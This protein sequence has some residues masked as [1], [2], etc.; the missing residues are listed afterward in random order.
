MKPI[1]NAVIMLCA[2]AAFGLP[3]QALNTLLSFDGTD[4][5]DPASALIRS[6][7]GN[8]YGTT[9]F[10]G[11]NGAGTV[12][13]ITPTGTLTTLHSF[14]GTDGMD[15]QGA[16]VQAPDGA[17]YGT[18][19]AGGAYRNGTVLKIARDGSF[20]TLHSFNSTDG[21]EPG[22]LVQAIDG[23]FY[24]A[25]YG[26][27][28][29]GFGT[30]FKISPTGTLTTLYSF[31]S[32][33]ECADGG[34]PVGSLI[35]GANGNFYG[36]TTVGGGSSK[37]CKD[38]DFVVR[39]GT[40]FE[41]TRDGALTTL[42]NF[43]SQVGCTDGGVP[44]A[45]LV[46]ATDGGLYGATTQGGAYLYGTVFKITPR[47]ELT[48]LHAFDNADGAMPNAALIQ[49]IDGN[50]YGTTYSGGAFDWGTVFKI[51]ATGTLTTLHSFDRT[52]DG[53]EPNG[54]V[55][56]VYGNLY[57]T[58]EGGGANNDGTVFSLPVFAKTLPTSGGVGC[59]VKILGTNLTGATSV[60]FNGTATIFELSRPSK[61]SQP[62]PP[63]RAPGTSR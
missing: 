6:I 61:L 20:T 41:I 14:D 40:V 7:D 10:G 46:Q 21:S 50:F 62:Y 4:G 53:T 48:T 35:Q 33:S 31:C 5:E 57:G 54:L 34:Y 28:A 17:L 26:G 47:G 36:T 18:T 58:T 23:E 2:T 43:C 44:N 45:G 24:G 15:P 56:G 22:T 30:V 51:T 37:L 11:A 29:S 19:N 16:L 55:Q 1:P 42:Y 59:A 8:L 38:G 32:Q 49:A 39:C 12:F 60:T 9:L 52:T 13:K 27:G 3:A 25:T 63:A